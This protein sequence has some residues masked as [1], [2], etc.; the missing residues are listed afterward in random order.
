MCERIELLS[1][2][3]DFQCSEEEMKKKYLASIIFYVGLI[4]IIEGIVIGVT[5]MDETVAV[6]SFF[7]GIILFA[8][9]LLLRKKWKKKFLSRLR[10][11]RQK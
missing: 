7:G 4:W 2:E 8:V 3:T 11:Q 1:H 10:K 5:G 6:W 9:G